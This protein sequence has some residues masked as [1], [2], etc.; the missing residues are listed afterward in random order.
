MVCQCKENC[1]CRMGLSRLHRFIKCEG[2]VR[3]QRLVKVAR[4]C[5]NKMDLSMYGG[6]KRQCSKGLPKMRRI[7]QYTEGFQY[8]EGLS[9]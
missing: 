1:Q 6:F 9:M 3:T 7:C 5:Q 4:V 8:K 2:F